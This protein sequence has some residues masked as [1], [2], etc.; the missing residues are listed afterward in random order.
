MKNKY[1]YISVIIPAYNAEKCLE[2][3]VNS[4]I[5]QLYEP[6]EII[7]IN[8]GSVDS[9][10]N[11]CAR[12]ERMYKNIKIINSKNQGVSAAR[13]LGIEVAKGEWICFM[14]SDDRMLENSLRQMGDCASKYKIEWIVGNFISQDEEKKEKV[15]N[16][17]Y[18]T[19][20]IHIGTPDELPEF[21]SA[22][23]FHC[24]WGKLY[25]KS[26]VETYKIR[27][28]NTIQYGED[29]L[30]NSNYITHVKKFAVLNTPVY[31]YTYRWGTGLGCQSQ[32]DEWMLQKV[33]C[34]TIEKNLS[35]NMDMT[36]KTLKKMNHFYF[37]QCIAS[38]ERSIIEKDR[39]SQKKILRDP[40]FIEI[41]Q[42]EKETHS[43]HKIDYF[44]LK[45]KKI[46]LY[47]NLHK[48]YAQIKKCKEKLL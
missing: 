23:N 4:I 38:L 7:I 42:R 45:N 32:K 27:F 1:P 44:L 3:S 31:F 48:A 5:N 12:L 18:F 35:E 19:E 33:L 10:E 17:Q 16:R 41:L 39:K 8:D 43:I 22:R 46:Y 13:N 14:D 15:L 20:A 28:D 21:S 34:R 9:T 6:C 11:I 26:I 37:S 36:A 47:Y 2:E 30:F 24:V 25:V 40:Y 29:L